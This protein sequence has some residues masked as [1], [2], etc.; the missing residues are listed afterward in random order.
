MEGRRE[1]RQGKG[2]KERNTQ[3]ISI[4]INRINV[5]LNSTTQ[6]YE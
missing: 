1:G 3:K 4:I 2:R 6:S 5:K